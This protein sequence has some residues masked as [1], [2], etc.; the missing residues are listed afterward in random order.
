[1]SEPIKN[2]TQ[3]WKRKFES[4]CKEVGELLDIQLSL[5]EMLRRTGYGQ[6]QI[7]AYHEL[8]EE[9]ERLR[10]SQ[11]KAFSALTNVAKI[12]HYEPVVSLETF[13]VVEQIDSIIKEMMQEK[14]RTKKKKA[15]TELLCSAIGLLV[16]CLPIIQN[17]AGMMASITQFAPLDPENQAK[18]DQTDYESE[19]LVKEIPE[20]F[21]T[22]ESQLKEIIG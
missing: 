21:S 10:E 3:E 12:L 9:N 6:G 18:H 14:E 11:K 13:A 17:D 22:N 8:C 1:M 4:A 15:Q 5:T 2:E 19:K 16:R 7:D 20:F